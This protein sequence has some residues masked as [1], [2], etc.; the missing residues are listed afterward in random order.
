MNSSVDVTAIAIMTSVVWV[1]IVVIVSVILAL[2]VCWVTL[3][4]AK[5]QEE[6]HDA[7]Y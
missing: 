3:A 5:H 1:K 6:E 2:D 4:R 7:E